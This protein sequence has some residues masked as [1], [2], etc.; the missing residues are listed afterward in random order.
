MYSLYADASKILRID[1]V[2]YYYRQRADSAMHKKSVNATE[3][4]V[5]SMKLMAIEYREIL[6]M[7]KV[8]KDIIEEVQNRVKLAVAAAMFRVAA[9]KQYD[10]NKLMAELKDEGLYPYKLYWGSLKPN[11]SFK[12]TIIE[13]MKFLFPFEPYYKLFT[14]II[15]KIH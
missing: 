9:D 11:T 12:H 4:Y 7:R 14:Y 3:K 13:W 5:K 10:N 6:D 1:G 15:R 8:P 2:L